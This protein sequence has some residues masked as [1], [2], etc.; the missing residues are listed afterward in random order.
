MNKP[1]AVLIS[2]VHYNL[3]TLEVADAAMRQ[4]ILKA[5][6]L[7]VP[8]VDLGDLTD[9]KAN[10]R[11]EVV[12]RLLETFK[13]V[14]IKPYLLVGNHS[15]INEKSKD[16]ALNFLSHLATI[17]SEPYVPTNIIIN[18]CFPTMIPYQYDQSIF[19]SIKDGKQVVWLLHQGIIGSN[20]GDYIQ[21]NSALSKTLTSGRRV[22]SGH[23]HQ[24]QDIQLPDNGVWSYCGNPYTLTFGEANDP[25]KGFQILMEDGS[26]EFVPT[27]LRKH[28]I[29]D[30]TIG[31]NSTD[32]SFSSEYRPGDILKVRVKGTKE[33][34]HGM[35]K[36]TVCVLLSLPIDIHFTLEMIPID[37][38]T[39][40][41][42]EAQS[43]P[44][45]IDSLIDTLD[46][47][48]EQKKRLKNMWRQM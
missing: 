23:Y 46:S 41:V 13:L 29:T 8:L 2:D 24:R 36:Q 19:S 14:K 5:N 3:Q 42:D 33:R 4:A 37:I 11:A 47:S 7:N 16:N 27:N 15:K 39:K 44:E 28:V 9:N 48:K 18:N 21:D 12:N 45:V 1:I 32:Y 31:F 43:Q 22:I 30:I 10:L 17:V 20:S 25:E 26:L 6:T 38:H 40:T 35:T 34:L